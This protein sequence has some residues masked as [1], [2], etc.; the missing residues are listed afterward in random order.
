MIEKSSPKQGTAPWS[1][2]ASDPV[3][4]P[5][6]HDTTADVCII[7]AGIAGLATAY[8]L[9]SQGRRV[10]VLDDGPVGGGESGKTT[11]HL[12]SV[13]DDGFSRI[14]KVHGV[15]VS[16]R[17]YESHA[18][19]IDWYE[20]IV[21]R[22]RI[23][24]DFERV[25]GFLFLPPGENPELLFHEQAAAQRAGVSD[26]ERVLSAPLTFDTGPCLRFPRQAQIEPLAFLLALAG[27]VERMGGRI[28]CGSHVQKIED[29]SGLEVQCENGTSVR[30][31]AV[32]VATNSPINDIVTMHTKQYAYRTYAIAL[33][34]ERG[35]VPHAL[36]WDT[37]QE[38]GKPDGPYH[39]V[40]VGRNP[41][42]I[43]GGTDSHELLIVGGEDHK[44]GQ[45]DDGA[46][47]WA[48]LEAWAKARFPITGAVEFRWSGQVME[49]VDYLAFIGPNPTG[50][51]G[52]YIVTGD[53]G[54][55]MTHGAI[56]GMLL[57]DLI[58][59]RKNPWADVYKPGRLTPR[60]VLEYARENI[61]VAAQYTDWVLP[62]GV[63]AVDDIPPGQAAV[64]R[65]G[66]KLLACYRDPSGLMHTRSAVCPH[67]G[68]IVKW[69][70]AEMTWDCPCHG[71]RF[72]HLGE[73]IN[74]PANSD[75]A[76]ATSECGVSV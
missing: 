42:S 28:C 21:S 68:G 65:E 66:L 38:A 43:R 48:R 64:V 45:A 57:P 69:N 53:S 2:G 49:P 23:D 76:E 44:T 50:P 61:N 13:I 37:S 71:S 4:A 54:M 75:L 12:S 31:G 73:V 39:Y 16:R 58:A 19:A 56:A 40:R 27:A 33:P 14:E 63:D 36:Y 51:A 24:C 30:A 35:V 6:D 74:G 59:G 8:E 29:R 32:V 9:A 62:G 1:E 15:E 11:A 5:L 17:C 46:A 70:S 67:L 52:V 18:A 26:V 34:I 10:V 60:T 25:D 55:G 7:G 20:S 3:R 41:V 72:D 22:E 47:R